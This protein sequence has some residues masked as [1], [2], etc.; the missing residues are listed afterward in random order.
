MNKI[1]RTCL[2]C[3]HWLELTSRPVGWVVVLYLAATWIPYAA[4]K[5]F[6]SITCTSANWRCEYSWSAAIS[7]AELAG[8]LSDPEMNIEVIQTPKK[9]KK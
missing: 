1:K 7:A 6:F 8:A 4:Q 2:W 3:Y 5:S 9:R